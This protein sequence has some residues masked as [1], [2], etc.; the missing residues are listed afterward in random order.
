VAERSIFNLYESATG[1]KY[2]E[3]LS[4][5]VQ[6]RR[7][8]LADTDL[9]AIACLLEECLRYRNHLRVVAGMREVQR[10]REKLQ[11]R[12]VSKEQGMDACLQRA[13]QSEKTVD[14][15]IEAEKLGG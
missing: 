6:V 8:Q 10:E 14:T 3:R 15:L 12:G 1:E 13:A 2:A 9:K 11:K 5:L 4:L 7:K